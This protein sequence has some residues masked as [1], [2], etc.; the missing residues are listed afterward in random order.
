MNRA[1]FPLTLTLSPGER[2]Q[3]R[4]R[5][6]LPSVC[7]LSQRVVSAERGVRSSLPM[8]L[9]VRP[10]SAVS[11]PELAPQSRESRRGRGSRAEIAGLGSWLLSPRERAGVRGNGSSE[12]QPAHA[13]SSSSR[14][15]LIFPRLSHRPTIIRQ[16]MRRAFLQRPPYRVADAVL[17]PPQVAVPE[18]QH[19][20]ARFLQPRVTLHIPLLLLW[21][22]MLASIQLDIHK[23]LD[24]EEIQHV[25]PETMLPSKLV[26]GEPPIPQPG[27]QQLLR[28]GVF[29]AKQPGDL[30][31]VGHGESLAV[32]AGFLKPV[33]RATRLSP[34]PSPLPRGEG[35]TPTVVVQFMCLCRLVATRT[36]LALSR[37]LTLLNL[38]PAP[39]RPPSPQG[40]GLG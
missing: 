23:R 14:S 30:V 25:L 34:H 19:L 35:A 5:L 27:P 17:V 1:P 24:A 3:P 38:Q 2:G 37:S 32:T 7:V 39:P 13:A 6:G 26:A 33:G 16:R 40:R 12:S 10:A 9:C 11:V 15:R 31:A 28:P 18:P 22:A 20:H 29:L 36:T 8:N 21:E 4:P